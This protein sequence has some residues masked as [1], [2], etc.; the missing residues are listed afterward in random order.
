MPDPIHERYQLTINT[1]TP[2]H[3]GTGETLNRDYD[4]V[5][6]GGRTWVVNSDILADMIY[7]RDEAALN[8]MISGTGISDLLDNEDY[9]P[10]SRLFRYVMRG[11]PRAGSRGAAI[12]QQLKNVWDQGYIPGSSLKGAVRTA[13]LNAGWELR[14]QPFKVSDLH[15]APNARVRYPEREAAKDIELELLVGNGNSQNTRNRD[16]RD[17]SKTAPN[18]DL[19]RAL[20]ISDTLP[21]ERRQFNLLN[22]SVWTA[23]NQGKGA[24]IELEAIPMETELTATLTLDLYLLNKVSGHL[25]WN[26]DH[27]RIIMNIPRMVNHWTQKRLAAD[28]DRVRSGTWRGIFK[29]LVSYYEGKKLAE[30][31]FILQL[32]WGGGWDSKTLGEYLT[33]NQKVFA[34]VVRIYQRQLDRQKTFKPGSRFP[35]SRRMVVRDNNALFTLGWIKVRMDKVS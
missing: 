30:N 5:V 27:R 9:D 17:K 3:I 32:G 22:V 19:L 1:L 10:Q 12:Q 2:V 18:F 31:E 4:F 35:I 21:D 25:G 33:G 26:K 24:P 34:E 28:F 20:H 15:E 6:K 23:A 11:E 14:G 7:D 16:Q 29:E 13:L 8:Q